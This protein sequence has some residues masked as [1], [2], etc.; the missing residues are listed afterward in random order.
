MN[1]MTLQRNPTQ[2][3]N[4]H[5]SIPLHA[6]SPKSMITLTWRKEQRQWQPNAKWRSETK[7]NTFQDVVENSDLHFCSF[8]AQI[9]FPRFGELDFVVFP[10]DQHATGTKFEFPKTIEKCGIRTRPFNLQGEN[11]RAIS[12]MLLIDSTTWNA[13]RTTRFLNSWSTNEFEM[14]N[15]VCVVT[16][17]ASKVWSPPI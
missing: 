10:A 1:F 9:F 14:R 7:W 3:E 13:F 12:I 6:R 8:S 2:N 5:I 4:L 17:C 15:L 16:K 11:R